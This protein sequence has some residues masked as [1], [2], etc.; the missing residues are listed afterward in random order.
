MDGNRRYARENGI[1]AEEGYKK[2]VETLRDCVEWSKDYGFSNVVA[3]AFSKDNWKRTDTDVDSVFE[4]FKNETLEND[5]VRVK[6]V[7]DLEDFSQEIQDKFKEVEEKTKDEKEITLWV[8]ASYNGRNE[9]VKAAKKLGDS[10]S[11]ENMS[12]ELLPTPELV[13]RTGTTRRLSGFML[14]EV[15]YAELF[16]LNKCWS[17]FNKE[18]FNKIINEYNNTLKNGGK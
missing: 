14:W 6:F 16:F 18:D 5:G 12:K 17:D 7:G 13:I 11:I 10:I 8:L 15:E 4:I 9:I 1:S 2:G 3:Y